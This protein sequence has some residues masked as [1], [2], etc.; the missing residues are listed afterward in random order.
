MH[1]A[2]D[3]YPQNNILIFLR[4]SI[5]LDVYKKLVKVEG[6]DVLNYATYP[7]SSNFL[8]LCRIRVFLFLSW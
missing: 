2:L 3:K 6:A 5:S 1:S 8:R 7:M 4:T